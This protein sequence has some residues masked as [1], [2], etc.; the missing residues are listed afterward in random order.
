MKLA[1]DLLD[2]LSTSWDPRKLKAIVTD[3]NGTQ[4]GWVCFSPAL[5]TA[6]TAKDIFRIFIEIS[7]TVKLLLA[8]N[9]SMDPAS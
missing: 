4:D 8:L 5:T 6:E 9:L 2:M 3:T 1:N 7:Y